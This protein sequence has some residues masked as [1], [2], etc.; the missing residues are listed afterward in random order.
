MT[1]EQKEKIDNL[2]KQHKIFRVYEG[3]E[4]DAPVRIFQ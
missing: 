1:P 4:I 2:I 3:I